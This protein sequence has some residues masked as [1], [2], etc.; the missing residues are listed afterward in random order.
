M[1]LS[2]LFGDLSDKKEKT[3]QSRR[4]CRDA[5]FFFLNINR[6]VTYLHQFACVQR[7]QPMH[8][9]LRLTV[10]GYLLENHQNR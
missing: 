1:R 9:A 2:K 3:L 10:P 4:F 5:T 6:S 7:Q 8:P